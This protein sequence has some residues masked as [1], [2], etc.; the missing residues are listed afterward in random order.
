MFHHNESSD[1]Y[2]PDYNYDKYNNRH[3]SSNGLKS[4]ANLAFLTTRRP[5]EVIHVPLRAIRV[6]KHNQTYQYHELRRRL[7]NRQ[8]PHPLNS[9]VCDQELVAL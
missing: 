5:L 1:G 2:K 3:F 9:E 7:M 6:G 4:W 8:H